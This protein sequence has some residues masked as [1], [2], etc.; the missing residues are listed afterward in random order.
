MDRDN[1]D[2]TSADGIGVLNVNQTWTGNQ[3]H[4]GTT[5]LSNTLKVGVN[6]TGY[7]VQFFGATSG[8]YMLWD[9]STDDLVLAGAAQLYL[10][11]AGGGE[12]LSSDGTDLTIN[13][14]RNINLTCAS[15]DVVIPA[16]IGLTFGDAAEKIEGD[17]TDLT[18]SGNNIKLTAVADVVVPA[19]VGI[20][21]GDAA[22]KIEGDGTNLT[23]ASSADI[24]LTATGDVNIPSGV[25]V[26]FGD[27]AEKIEGDGT[28]LTISGNNINLTAVADVIVPAN[29]GVTFGTGEKIEGDN[30]NLTVT[31]QADINLTAA[32][33]INIP[34]NV[35]LTF[36]DDAEKIEGDG[37]DLTIAGNN[38]N[39]TATADVVVPANVGI[40]FGTG[41]KIEG[42]NT[43]LTV[44]S[45]A[46][47]NMTAGTD[48]NVTG[49]VILSNA[50]GP[51]LADEAATATNPT[52][53]P[54][55]AE[56]DTGIG[57][58]AADTPTI[59]TGGT[60]RMRIDSAGKIFTG[61]ETLN[62]KMSAGGLTLHQSTAD[63]EIL[64]LKSSD[65]GHGMTDDTEADTWFTISKAHGP[66]GGANLSAWKDPD[67]FNAQALS[68][69]GIL[70]EAADTTK[71]TGAAG[72]VDIKAYILSGSSVGAPG[73]NQNLCSITSG[74]TCR[75]LFDAEGS[76][77]SDVEWTTYDTYDD[78]A[79]ITDMESEVL[80]HEDEAQTE[81]RRALEAAG[82]I[83]KDSWHTENGRPR[84]M[85][86]FTKLSMLHHGALIQIGQAYDAVRERL[87]AAESKLKMLE[88][89]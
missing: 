27:D 86:N 63:N 46:A 57:W 11:D 56:V 78:I 65:V 15:G 54:N 13:S 2:S 88:A 20:T 26:T 22:E 31:S 50:A 80:L 19:N 34:A 35:G 41:E 42:D 55:K 48:V 44:T 8:A 76:G 77:H 84:V 59:I 25:G 29:V 60:E 74:T 1:V 38:I 9:E 23:V 53:I 73:A 14:G 66:S 51:Q 61:A 85:V 4:T 33:D 24:N 17:G 28:D 70:G 30:T 71:G 64:A 81:R 82:I 49:D 69:R 5:Q 72:I 18:I 7:D 3:T 12:H 89:V 45:Q 10:Y 36:G 43:N 6:D 67:G 68:L 52:L 39:L 16:N 32:N 79:L 37:T 83:G 21:F 75:F 87:D 58:A 62:A 40:T 47:I